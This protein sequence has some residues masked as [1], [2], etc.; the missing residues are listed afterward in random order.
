MMTSAT[1]LGSPLP[2]GSLVPRVLIWVGTGLALG[3]VATLIWFNALFYPGYGLGGLG[4]EQYQAALLRAVEVA[5]V[6]KA[7]KD[8]ATAASGSPGLP[9]GAPPGAPVFVAP[10]GAGPPTDG[11]HGCGR[12]RGGWQSSGCPARA[13]WPRRR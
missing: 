13:S 8:S 4:Q 6:L 2:V 7:A 12:G 5:A 10:P 9:P 1:G 3:M 11:L